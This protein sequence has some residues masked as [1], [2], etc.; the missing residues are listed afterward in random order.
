MKTIVTL[1]S[2]AL[3]TSAVFVSNAWAHGSLEPKHGGVVK[4]AHDMVFELVR[5]EK[6]VSLYVRDHG[7]AYPTTKLAADVVVL[8]SKE[9]SEASFIP[10]GGNRMV[11]DITINDGAKVLIRVSE[12][13]HHP[14]TIRYS[15]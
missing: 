4:E 12:G 13:N 6:L 1:V 10:T 14:I 5:E 9:K 8:A 15:F 3:I 2:I 11:A 7:E